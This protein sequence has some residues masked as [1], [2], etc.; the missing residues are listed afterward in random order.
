M[1]LL[2][3]LFVCLFCS[4]GGQETREAG[5]GWPG[6][7]GQGGVRVQPAQTPLSLPHRCVP[8][9]ASPERAV[10]VV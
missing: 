5:E 6:P 8:P 1:S 4:P 9:D 10:C 3:C 2:I 7:E